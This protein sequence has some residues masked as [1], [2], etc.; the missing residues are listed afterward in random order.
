MSLPS[1]R[2]LRP[3]ASSRAS[4]SK[5]PA[6]A[7]ACAWEPLPREPGLLA[8]LPDSAAPC[9]LSSSRAPGPWGL[10]V[11]ASRDPCF[12]RGPRSPPPPLLSREREPPTSLDLS[13]ESL[14]PEE[15]SRPS[16]APS[17]SFEP[18]DLSL[19]GPEPWLSRNPGPR[20]PPASAWPVALARR[21]EPSGPSWVPLKV[22]SSTLEPGGWLP[23]PARPR[24]NPWASEPGAR[25]RLPPGP[26]ADSDVASPLCPGIRLLSGTWPEPVPTPSASLLPP[27]GRSSAP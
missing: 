18:A 14:L 8:D 2:C 20:L 12:P 3:R 15:P 7:P 5:R 25:A 13:P 11:S 1:G 23:A 26:S 17:K 27:S 10:S 24:S 16:R 19:P 21:L 6:L 4:L 9:P 22:A